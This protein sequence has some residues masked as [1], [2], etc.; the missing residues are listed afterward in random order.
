VARCSVLDAAVDALAPLVLTSMPR[1]AGRV[2]ALQVRCRGPKYAVYCSVEQLPRTIR[3]TSIAVRPAVNSAFRERV[4]ALAQEP[5]DTSTVSGAVAAVTRMRAALQEAEAS[6]AHGATPN[7]SPSA[8]PSPDVGTVTVINHKGDATALPFRGA[9][10]GGDFKCGL[11]RLVAADPP[12]ACQELYNAED[13]RGAVV[14]VRR[15]DCFFESKARQVQQAG[16]SAVIVC[17]SPL[18]PHPRRHSL[19]YLLAA[20]RRYNVHER[21]PAVRMPSGDGTAT[22]VVIAAG[23]VDAAGGTRLQDVLRQARSAHHVATGDGGSVWVLFSAPGA[24]EEDVKYHTGA[25]VAEAEGD[26]NGGGLGA[27]AASEGDDGGLWVGGDSTAG[28]SALLNALLSQ[29]QHGRQGF[30]R[31]VEVADDAGDVS[32]G[33]GE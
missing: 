16:G 2:A 3:P 29:Q 21:D 6:R 9:L 5:R 4:P 14:L 31:R 33:D 26:A 17:V 30:G 8:F 20:C 7:L 28:A 22:D 13:L 19:A 32:T 10:F 1:W 23:M 18:A 15:G 27:A 11:F 12:S 24:C 25:D